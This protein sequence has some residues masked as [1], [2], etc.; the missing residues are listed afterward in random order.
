MECKIIR[1]GR[2]LERVN[3]GWTVEINLVSW[4]GKDPKWEIRSW[5]E[6]HTKCGKGVTLSEDALRELT[7]FLNGVKD[8]EDVE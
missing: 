7:N 4:Y 5:N 6:D 8:E 1:H 2:I 3:G